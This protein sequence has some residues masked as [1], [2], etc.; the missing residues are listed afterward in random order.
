MVPV[1]HQ[2]ED[3]DLVCKVDDDEGGVGHAWLLEVSASR[4]L[5]VQLLAPVLIRPLGHLEQIDN[6]YINIEIHRE[7][8]K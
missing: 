4:V 1:P 3:S 5:P 2:E 7:I 8:H 6:T